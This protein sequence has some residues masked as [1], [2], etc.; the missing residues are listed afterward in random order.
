MVQS[1]QETVS[2]LPQATI[3]RIE[4]EGI[5]T[6]K[7][8]SKQATITNSRFYE[9]YVIG[10]KS[11][12]LRNLE[13]EQEIQRLRIGIEAIMNFCDNQNNSHENIWRLA[14]SLLSL[15]PD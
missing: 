2:T 13:N 15:N 1:N 12:A 3:E 5:S 8:S 9:G 6:R 7:K 10:A 4:K 14:E 11:E